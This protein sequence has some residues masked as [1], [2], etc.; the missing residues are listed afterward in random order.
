MFF[1]GLYVILSVRQGRNHVL[2]LG[3]KNMTQFFV[4]DQEKSVEALLYLAN[5]V[6]D[7]T[8]MSILKLLYFADKTSAMKFGPV[9][10]NIYNLMKLDNRQLESLGFRLEGDRS[11]KLVPLRDADTHQLSPSD[12]ECLDAI[13][14]VY[15][16]RPAWDLSAQTHQDPAWSKNWRQNGSESVPIPLEDILDTFDDGEALLEYLRENT[17]IAD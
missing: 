6:K 4:F 17:H 1:K 11:Y 5:R 3:E 16:Q 2:F 9:A 13:I 12:I 7:P 8:K 10:S 14:E 15:G